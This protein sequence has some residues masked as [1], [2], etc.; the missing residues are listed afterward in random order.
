MIMPGKWG[1]NG[2]IQIDT[3]Y[4]QNTN[5]GKRLSILEGVLW[6][7]SWMDAFSLPVSFDFK[8]LTEAPI[9]SY[10]WFFKSKLFHSRSS[11]RGFYFLP[12][13]PSFPYTWQ[14][15]RQDSCWTYLKFKR[16]TNTN[17]NL[18]RVNIRWK[19]FWYKSLLKRREILAG[20]R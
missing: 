5:I 16:L 10:H 13:I 14:R 19:I 11:I 9:F 20:A 7:K 12:K 3:K 4:I 15:N 8:T 6:Y 17:K 18:T 1:R 2:Q